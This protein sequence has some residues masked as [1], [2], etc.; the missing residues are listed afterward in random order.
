MLGKDNGPK[1]GLFLSAMAYNDIEKRLK[2]PNTNI[3]VKK[4]IKKN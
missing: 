2:K 4:I 3:H 1:M